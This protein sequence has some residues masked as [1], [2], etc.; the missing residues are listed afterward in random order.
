[1]SEKQGWRGRFYEDF[2][3]GDV[4]RHP[5]GRNVTQS[6]NNWFT[7]LPRNAAPK[8]RIFRNPG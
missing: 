2:E 7:L 5:L 8:R 4:Y 1:M 6:D 3:V